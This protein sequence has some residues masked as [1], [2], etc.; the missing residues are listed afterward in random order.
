ME[1]TPAFQLRLIALFFVDQDFFLSNKNHVKLE[2]FNSLFFQWLFQLL[3]AYV[4]TYK[5]LPTRAVVEQELSQATDLVI[6]DEERHFIGEFLAL[7]SAGFLLDADYI[8][9]NFRKFV[10]SRTISVI[11]QTDADL[12]IQT[13]EFDHLSASLRN[14]SKQFEEED[15]LRDKFTFSLYNLRD[16][17]ENEGGIKTG[18][19]LIDNI[20][21]GLM[22]KELS[23]FLADT[24][25][26]KSA[27]L[28][29]IGG[30]A[31]RQMKKVLHI[32]LEMS[33][34]RTLIR[35]LTN[36]AEP[37]DNI[38]YDNIYNFSPQ[39]DVYKF[40]LNLREKYE[41]YIHIFEFPTGKCTIEDIYR[42]LDKYPETELLNVDYLELITPPVVRKEI[43]NEARDI[44]IALRGMASERGIHVCTATQANRLAHN[45]RFVRKDLVSEDYNKV[46]IPD[47][48]IGMGQTEEDAR[49]KEVVLYL[50]RSRNSE[51]LFAERYLMDF[52]RMRFVFMKQ[53]LLDGGH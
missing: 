33:F 47:V 8:K 27:L 30:H 18:I 11:L 19:T 14:A 28:T 46:R 41:D 5:S 24:N 31:L 52:Q 50:I 42:L 53:E 4:R 38:V 25:V 1:F 39:E 16:I 51:K 45:K 22:P 20:V 48:G 9:T 49:R 13:G 32:T 3:D 40:V 2:F 37:E 35:Y 17:Y 44:T 21:G 10:K 36:L 23:I 6:L 12:A 29:H 43:R 7:L 26:G 34:S 15:N